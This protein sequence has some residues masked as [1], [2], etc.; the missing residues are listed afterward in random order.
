MKYAD[1][2]I[3]LPLKNLFTYSIPD[4]ITDCIG[5]GYR[6]IVP[7]GAR[8][9]YTA[10]VAKI[11]SDK[12]QDY[13]VKDIDY[14]IDSFPLINREQLKLWEWIS[15][16]YMCALGEVYVAAVPAK[17]RLESE[18]FLSLTNNDN[19]LE[20]LSDAEHSIIAYL[21]EKGAQKLSQVSKDLGIK[22]VLP[23]AHSLVFKGSVYIE[24]NVEERY[25]PKNEIFI[26]LN[27]DIDDATA[28][29]G[30]ARKQ[31]ELYELLKTA[32]KEQGKATYLRSEIQQVFG[33]TSSVLKALVDKG[34][35]IQFSQEVSRI[36]Q[37]EGASREPYQLSEYQQKSLHEIKEIFKEKDVCLLHGVTSS[38]KTEIYI[39]LIVEQ[40]RR[41]KQVLFLVPEIALT[42]QLTSR[43]QAVF[44]DKL[45]V[46]HSRI[47]DNERAEIWLKMQSDK[48]FDVVIGV[49]SSMFLPYQQ[50]GLVIVD[51]EHE[52]GYKQVDPAPRY[53]ARDTSIILAHSF[54][55]KVL[56]GSATPSI[57]TYHNATIGKYGL[58]TLSNRHND[59][60]MPRIEI[61]NTSELRRKKI[62]KSVLTPLMIESINNALDNKQQII[63]F[64][65]RRGFAPLFE[66]KNCG[67]TPKC[68]HCDVSLTFH[69]RQGILKC[70]YCNTSYRVVEKCAVCNENSVEQLGMG[71]EMLEEEVARL[72]PDAVVDRLDTDTTSGKNSY[73]RII[74]NFQ[75]RKTD[76]LVGT[77]MLSKGLDFENVSIVGI[78]AADGLLNHP[79]FRS[80]E[81]GFQLMMQTAGRAGRKNGQGMVIIQA[82]DPDI[83]LFKYLQSNDYVNFFHMQM[84]ERKLF[85]YPP[86]TRLIS[87]VLRHRVEQV[88]GSGANYFAA[89]L[90]QKLGS[91]VLGPNTP[92]ISYIQRYHIREILLKIDA[93]Y[94]YIKVR[95]ALRSV[96][97]NFLSVNEYKYVNFYYD[98]DLV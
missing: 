5:V 2:I 51:E 44:G 57:E 15:F 82:S 25:K 70:H 59:V 73:E 83:A 47:N 4:N 6:V 23:Y 80:H 39:H 10:I 75:N 19:N 12:P 20:S 98:V 45:V 78:I 90:K 11:H 33:F 32:E 56:L 79:N 14:V 71:T 49:R 34:V 77:Q 37:Y 65:N 7:F 69:K 46:Y 67:W 35:V 18:T 43:L 28:I 81:R 16:Y 3:P 21:M 29:I 31:F 62:M 58:V 13:E 88:V 89:E 53:N 72:F 9:Y 84:A 94:S 54:G 96:E 17:H 41:N 93:N 52:V 26:R 24:D 40:Q 22:D 76:I 8:K 61:E 30:G 63:L 85:N 27:P 55:A 91:I 60:E 87:I 50:L 38:G 66:C 97:Y 92:V 64:R 95:E 1:V 86:Y 36:N 68:K 48:P 74:N 42:T